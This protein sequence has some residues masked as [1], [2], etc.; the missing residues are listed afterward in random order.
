MRYIK[1]Y[2]VCKR[3]TCMMYRYI[4]ICVCMYKLER[5]QHIGNHAK[6]I[7]PLL[8]QGRSWS[9][10]VLGHESLNCTSNVSTF[11]SYGYIQFYNTH[12]QTKNVGLA[13]YG[14]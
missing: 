12:H 3:I 6:I 11:F 13:G 10:E 9:R 7:Y 2:D 14:N 4:S 8:A 5:L 1:S